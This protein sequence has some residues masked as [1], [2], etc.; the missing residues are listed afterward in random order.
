MVIFQLEQ[1]E[2]VFVAQ[3]F[4]A[5]VRLTGRFPLLQLLEQTLRPVE[6]APV[7]LDNVCS[8]PLEFIVRHIVEDF[9]DRTIATNNDTAWLW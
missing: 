4:Q 9:Q 5:A 7:R 2:P 1:R 6:V 3:I 8:E